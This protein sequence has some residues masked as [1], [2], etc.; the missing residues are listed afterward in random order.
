MN[1][2]GFEESQACASPLPGVPE[3]ELER[4]KDR[5]LQ[6]LVQE[7][8]RPDLDRRLRRAARQAA[9]LARETAYPLLVF[10]ALFE[11]LAQSASRSS[12][13][14]RPAEGDAEAVRAS[15]SSVPA[16]TLHAAV[17]AGI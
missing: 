15:P 14:P 17:L 13:L 12:L 4:L 9:A 6:R 2:D 7:A 3:T 5:L 8:E 11:E 16:A 1:A 10:P